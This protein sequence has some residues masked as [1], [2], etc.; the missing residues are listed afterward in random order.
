MGAPRSPQSCSTPL[1]HLTQ[2]SGFP[3]SQVVGSRVPPTIH[4]LATSQAKGPDHTWRNDTGVHALVTHKLSRERP[5]RGQTGR[6]VPGDKD[7]GWACAHP[8]F[9]LIALRAT[10][11][12]LPVASF[13]GDR[14]S[15]DLGWPRPEGSRKWSHTQQGKVQQIVPEPLSSDRCA[16]KSW[17][18]HRAV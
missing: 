18:T 7:G 15:L 4:K 6:R 8:G 17:P 11:G 12:F 1:P 5:G 14:V 13:H 10:L 9:I 2:F 3:E 16:V